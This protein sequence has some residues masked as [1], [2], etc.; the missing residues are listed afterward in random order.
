MLDYTKFPPIVKERLH[1]S[2]LCRTRRMGLHAK[3][4]AA[5]SSLKSP[6]CVEP[7]NVVLFEGYAFFSRS[8]YSLRTFATLGRTTNWQYGCKLLLR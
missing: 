6:Q 7:G 1:N 5:T 2:P 4:V 3:T 8:M